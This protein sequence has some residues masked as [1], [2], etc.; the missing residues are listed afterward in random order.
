MPSQEG[1][2]GWSIVWSSRGSRGHGGGRGGLNGDRG[3]IR[4]I[5]R[6]GYRGVNGG[7]GRGYMGQNQ[8]SNAATRVTPSGGSVL[9]GRVSVPPYSWEDHWRDGSHCGSGGRGSFAPREG[10]VRGRGN[11]PRS[12]TTVDSGSDDAA[13]FSSSSVASPTSDIWSTHPSL[14][15]SPTSSTPST[16]GWPIIDE[17]KPRTT[18]SSDWGC[19]SGSGGWE[20]PPEESALQARS[21]VSVRGRGAP[22]GRGGY[23]SRNDGQNREPFGNSSEGSAGDGGWLDGS[24]GDHRGRSAE[25]PFRGLSRGRGRG[26]SGERGRGWSGERGSGLSRDRGGIARESDA[27]ATNLWESHGRDRL[28]ETNI[29][30]RGRGGRGMRGMRGGRGGR[31]RSGGRDKRHDLPPPRDIKEGL[32]DPAILEVLVPEDD[33]WPIHVGIREFKVIGSY[34]WTEDRNPTILVPG[35]V[36]RVSFHSQ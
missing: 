18:A 25:E 11:A 28:D 2:E 30:G 31:G 29:R 17:E 34:S 3:V 9:G 22:R 19:E 33:A 20:R 5:G 35:D 10:R 4:G 21:G 1:T 15:T 36:L 12:E 6:G 16:Y 24:R 27:E 13:S 32:Q 8:V 14:A 7:L 23:F 26:L